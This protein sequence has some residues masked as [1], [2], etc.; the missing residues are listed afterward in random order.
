M[1]VQCWFGGNTA[2]YFCLL[3]VFFLN[4]QSKFNQ[5]FMDKFENEFFNLLA[6]FTDEGHR[7]Q[8]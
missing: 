8:C 4:N 1:V 5:V 2:N 6:Y 3:A 7:L